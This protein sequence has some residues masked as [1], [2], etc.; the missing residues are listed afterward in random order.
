MERIM[1]IIAP[2]SDKNIVED[3]EQWL[4][5]H[6]LKGTDLFEHYDDAV[7]AVWPAVYVANSYAGIFLSINIYLACAEKH[8]FDVKPDF[9][10]TA[11]KDG[12]T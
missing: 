2:S 7:K 3:V 8:G 12:F 10:K 4:E 5:A 11:Q 9:L 1:A 6:N